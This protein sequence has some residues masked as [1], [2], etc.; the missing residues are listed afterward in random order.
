MKGMGARNAEFLAGTVAR[1]GQDYPADIV[2]LHAGHNHSNE[3]QPVPGIVR[4]TE[5]IIGRSEDR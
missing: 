1:H 4:A 2:L 3:E 5:S